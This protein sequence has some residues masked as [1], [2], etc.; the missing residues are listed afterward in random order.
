[1]KKKIFKIPD[2]YFKD[3]DVKIQV[4]TFMCKVCGEQVLDVPSNWHL[5]K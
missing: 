4:P 3:I 1:M 5:K 2:D